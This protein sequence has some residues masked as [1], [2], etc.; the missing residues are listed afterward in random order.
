MSSF[1]QGS[2]VASEE[3]GPERA[4]DEEELEWLSNKDVFP[5]VESM[6][7]EVEAEEVWV[8][9]APRERT[10]GRRRV[11][12]M[13][14]TC[15]QASVRH[16]DLCAKKET[17]AMPPVRQEPTPRAEKETASSLAPVLSPPPQKATLGCMHCS[18]EK[19]PKWSPGADGP[20]TL[21]NACGLRF[22]EGWVIPVVRT[23]TLL[24]S[25]KKRRRSKENLAAGYGMVVLVE[26]LPCGVGASLD[27][28]FDHTVDL[29][30]SSHP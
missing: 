3:A 6:A 25:S 7:L 19:T 2:E 18:L 11:T 5:L 24:H 27:A 15:R 17:T 8:L 9:E 22:K 12:A 28:F 1:L 13:E 26:G 10:N 23:P 30:S 21:C 4:A 16:V 20:G 14:T 29:G